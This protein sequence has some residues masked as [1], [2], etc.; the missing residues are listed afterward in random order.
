[1]TSLTTI[2]ASPWQLAGHVRGH[3]AIENQLHWVRDVTV[4]KDAFQVRT[5]TAPR[6]MATVCNLAT[7]ALRLAGSTNTN[8]AAQPDLSP[9]SASPAHKT[10]ITTFGRNSAPRTAGAGTVALSYQPT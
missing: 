3:W 4:A 1:V 8:T 6:A 5:C 2:R 9:S 7:G 10:D